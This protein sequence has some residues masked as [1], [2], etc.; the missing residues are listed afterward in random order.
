MFG[1]FSK[2]KIFQIVSNLSNGLCEDGSNME[3]T[4]AMREDSLKLWKA[5]RLKVLYSITSCAVSIKVSKVINPFN[6]NKHT[7]YIG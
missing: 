1:C 3:M 5:R 2:Y 7:V 6:S 4:S